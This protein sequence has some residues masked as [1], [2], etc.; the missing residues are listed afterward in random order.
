MDRG[1]A[2]AAARLRWGVIAAITVMVLLYLAARFNLKFGQVHIEYRTHGVLPPAGRFV[3]DGTALLLLVALFH[4]IQVLRLIEGGELFSVGVIRRFR[5]FAFWLLLMV[6]FSV[7]APV[8]TS[9]AQGAP[10]QPHRFAFPLDVRELL[11]LGLA[12]LL[13]LLARL[14]ERAREIDAEMQE[15]V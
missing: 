3:G 4:L 5:S 11:T 9:L 15:I 14:L 13:F 2:R 1:I 8:L 7:F 6:A 10:G 12:L